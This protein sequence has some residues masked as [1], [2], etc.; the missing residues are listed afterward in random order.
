MARPLRLLVP[1]GWYHV[2]SRGNRQEKLFHDDQDRRRF[3][4]LVSEWPERFRV[5]VH[6]FVLMDN[7]YHVVVRTPEPNLT[8]AVRWLHVSYSSRFNWAH[9]LV[10]HLFAGR[11]RAV[12]IQDE[13]GVCEVARYVHLNPVRIGGLG[14]GKAEQRKARVVGGEDPG[15]VLVAQRLALL[16][17]Y[18]WSSWRVYAGAE[19]RPTWLE[20]G[21][22]GAG[23]GGR[24]REAQ[25][26]ALRAYTET[27]VREGRLESPWERLWGGLVLGDAEY[28]EELCRQ[29][30]TDALEQ[31]EARRLGRIRRVAWRDLVATA[32][33]EL[34]RKWS[35]MVMAHGDWGRDAIFYVA[36]RHGG[37]R[38]AEVLREVPGLNYQAAAQGVRRFRRG[39]ETDPAK[40]RL[41]TRLRK[42]LS[43]I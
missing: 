15:A 10:G 37:Y 28:A 30:K 4:G 16:H 8:D 31:T 34:G 33:K 5:E 19:P 35:E 12:V 22:V 7:H 13:R 38:L 1:G 39:L 18:A 29:T 11:F 42:Q 9:Q 32:E 27:P 2:T 41:V 21:I 6:A 24:S 17:N 25:R 20:T 14:L 40:E 3:L 36:T 26:A 43:I 23:C